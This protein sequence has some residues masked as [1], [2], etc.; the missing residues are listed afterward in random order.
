MSS[1]LPFGKID[2]EKLHSVAPWA[3]LPNVEKR[4]DKT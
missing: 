4:S 1:L 3:T 2:D